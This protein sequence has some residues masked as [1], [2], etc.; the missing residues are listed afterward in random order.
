MN[1]EKHGRERMHCL[2][3]AVIRRRLEDDVE[4]AWGL[5]EVF[6]TPQETRWTV[7]IAER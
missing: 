6:M 1:R 2:S 4:A 7:V 3:F 5:G